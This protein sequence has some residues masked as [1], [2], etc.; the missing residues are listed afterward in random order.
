ML[1]L[2]AETMPAVTVEPR[3]KGSPMAITQ[4]PMR[5]LSL[6]PKWVA[7]RGFF[8]VDFQQRQIGLGVAARRPWPAGC[9]PSLQGDRD[10]VA[11]LDHMIV[12]DDVAGGI[13]DEARAQRRDMTRRI[14]P[15]APGNS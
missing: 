6:S 3:P 5:A 14:G 15:W 1:R 2:R 13:D 12:G 4:S 9:V 8:G 11:V 10:L 7:G